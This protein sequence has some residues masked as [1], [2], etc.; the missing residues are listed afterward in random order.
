MKSY[1]PLLSWIGWLAT[2]VM[3][4]LV[5]SDLSDADACQLQQL[6]TCQR[7]LSDRVTVFNNC[8]DRLNALERQAVRLDAIE[9]VSRGTRIALFDELLRQQAKQ[10]D[11]TQRVNSNVETFRALFPDFDEYR[12][13]RGQSV[14]NNTLK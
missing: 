2:V 14:V 6:Q 10:Q 9:A 12:A 7:Q 1:L 5:W 4:V 3:A 8:L 11:E 13:T